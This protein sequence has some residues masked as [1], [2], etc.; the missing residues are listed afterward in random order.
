MTARFFSACRN[1]FATIG[2]VAVFASP[3]NM[4]SQKIKEGIG[5]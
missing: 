3:T 2:I 5:R 4:K 1:R